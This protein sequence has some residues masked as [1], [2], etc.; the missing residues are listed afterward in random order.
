MYTVYILRCSDGSLYTG[1]ALDLPSRLK[2]HETK[3]GSKYV[4]TR[5]P[6]KLVY[7]KE[8]PDKSSA[9]KEEI[10]IKKLSKILKEQLIASQNLEN[11]A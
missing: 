7:K 6:F 2:V 11:F 4:R 1:I 5:L 3:K 10:R 9:L 8:Y